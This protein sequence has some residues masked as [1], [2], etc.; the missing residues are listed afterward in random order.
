MEDE[1][2]QAPRLQ[3]HCMHTFYSIHYMHNI[4]FILRMQSHLPGRGGG[5]G[6]VSLTLQP[7]Q[8]VQLLNFC[9]SSPTG[10]HVYF[11]MIVICIVIFI[12]VVYIYFC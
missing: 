11:F 7:R 4:V 12:F 3:T 2:R 10:L 8:K 1:S 9:S 6:A 5:V